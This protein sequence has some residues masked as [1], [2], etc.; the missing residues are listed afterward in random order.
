MEKQ[1]TVNK[2][3]L[4]HKQKNDLMRSLRIVKD[5][6]FHYI[7]NG[8]P[9]EPT[10]GFILSDRDECLVFASFVFKNV[11]EKKIKSL[12][13]RIDFY[14]Y[15]NIPYTSVTFR[16]CKDN[17]SFGII[18]ENNKELKISRS[19]KREFIEKGASFGK[20]VYIPLPES[21]FTK[22]CVV[23]EAAEYSDG[24]AENLEITLKGAGKTYSLLDR[25]TQKAYDAA[26]IYK[27]HEHVFPTKNLPQFGN[28]SWLCCCGYKNS[29]IFEKC[30][31]C[32]R[33]K[34][35]Q[36]RLLSESAIENKR[37]ELVSISSN[38]QYHDKTR[39]PQNKYLENKQDK[40]KKAEAIKQSRENLIRLQDERRKKER[41]W[42]TKGIVTLAVFWAVFIGIVVFMVLLDP[43]KD[44]ESFL[45]M[46]RRILEGDKSLFEFFGA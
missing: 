32:S 35:V 30:E 13:V 38:L 43:G 22:M 4:K 1:A 31:K 23:L 8:S 16:Y 46:V 19:N 26:N 45:K 44:G 3:K 5:F 41:A 33:E 7:L 14:Y 12:T 27:F 15:Q 21:P 9:I 36:Q 24:S 42:L 11:S 40:L 39:F 2:R 25:V 29:H 10:E 37:N 20:N 34:S 17:L 18:N 6:G 28:T